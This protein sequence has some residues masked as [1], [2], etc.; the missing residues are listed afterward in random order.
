MN[1][2]HLAT[3]ALVTLCAPLVHCSSSSSA[4]A[5]APVADGG[6]HPA[7]PDAGKDPEEDAAPSQASLASMN[8]A[9]V[10][11]PAIS[12]K[13]GKIRAFGG[14]TPKGLD[15]SAESY[16]SAANGWTIET[17]KSSLRRYAHTAT[18]DATGEVYVIGGTTDGKTPTGVVETFSPASSGWTT[19]ADLPTPRLGLS[20]ATGKDGRI[21]TVGGRD[22]TGLPT[23]T[24][25]VYSPD[26]QSWSRGPSLP[27]KRLA[28]VAVTGADGKIYAIGGRDAENTP[29]DIVEVLDV[30]TGTWTN[31]QPMHS[32]RFWFG[33]AL[34]ADGAIYVVGGIA[35]EGF[36]DDIE[37][38]TPAGGWKSLKAMPE[39]RGSL[40]VAATSD[41]RVY[42]LGGTPPMLGSTQP[43]P[44]T[45]ILAF[46]T[47]AGVWLE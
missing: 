4:P 12:G 15:N 5:D 19:I 35:R 8:V 25:E 10:L 20:A 17:G 45:S 26:T 39:A 47:K 11:F 22:A 40:S 29:L 42:V 27:T 2:A 46:D 9:R 1:R 28:L 18:Q 16:D 32:A 33:G 21:Y 7:A 23:D 37:S 38:Y 14:L 31:A 43:P 3:F 13:D 6:A 34:G 36:L 30:D 41:G 44:V 24:V